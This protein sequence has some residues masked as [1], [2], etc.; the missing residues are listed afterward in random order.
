MQV[1]SSCICV[2]INSNCASKRHEE[3]QDTGGIKKAPTEKHIIRRATLQIKLKVKKKFSLKYV[4]DKNTAKNSHN[5]A[6]LGGP[7]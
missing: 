2:S 7:H 4:Q 3:Q 5:F 1:P 6:H